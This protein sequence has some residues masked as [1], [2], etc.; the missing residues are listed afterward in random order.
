MVRI[1]RSMYPFLSNPLPSPLVPWFVHTTTSDS[2]CS[3]SIPPL[4]DSNKATFSLGNTSWSNGR[5][6][7]PPASIPFWIM[8]FVPS[9]QQMPHSS[10]FWPTSPAAMSSFSLTGFRAR[11]HIC[12]HLNNKP[13]CELAID[14]ARYWELVGVGHRFGK[15]SVLATTPS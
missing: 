12:D 7:I 10:P 8:R 5:L 6:Y 3:Y 9:L 1:A 11:S 2:H 13:P 14:L 4:I 15:V